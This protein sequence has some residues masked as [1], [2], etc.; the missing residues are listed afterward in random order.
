MTVVLTPC[1]ASFCFHSQTGLTTNTCCINAA[2]LHP[3]HLPRTT[4]WATLHLSI[5]KISSLSSWLEE[6][7]WEKN[8]VGAFSLIIA[9]FS[10]KM[11][12]P[13]KPCLRSAE[14]PGKE[15]NVTDAFRFRAGKSRNRALLVFSEWNFQT[16]LAFSRSLFLRGAQSFTTTYRINRLEST[17]RLISLDQS[18]RKPLAQSSLFEDF[19]FLFLMFRHIAQ[20]KWA[21]ILIC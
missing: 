10:A 19:R 14:V 3:C 12:S 21:R 9:F 1:F 13:E 20:T 6:S 17:L 11:S 2:G 7:K 15:S 4:S 18:I 8:K 5:L 16:L